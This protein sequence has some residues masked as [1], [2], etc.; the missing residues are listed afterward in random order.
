MAIGAVGPL[1][2]HDLAV[3]DPVLTR[4]NREHDD[5]G[6]AAFRGQHTPLDIGQGLSG[7]NRRFDFNRFFRL[8]QAKLFPAFTV[9]SVG[10]EFQI[11][12]AVNTLTI[13]GAPGW[14][15]TGRANH[16]GGKLFVSHDVFFLL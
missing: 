2:G 14:I 11:N 10:K 5:F 7:S 3:R 9:K 6:I 16:L 13:P 1:A 12:P 4:L 15:A 8:A